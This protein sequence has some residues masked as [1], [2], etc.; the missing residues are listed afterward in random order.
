MVFLI[1]VG[2]SSPETLFRCRDLCLSFILASNN[3]VILAFSIVKFAFI[4]VPFLFS[5]E[6]YTASVNKF[7]QVSVVFWYLYLEVAGIE[8]GFGL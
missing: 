6:F 7:I 8:L 2:P 1:V 3:S 4:L 5:P